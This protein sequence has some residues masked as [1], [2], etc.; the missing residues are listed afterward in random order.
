MQ[1]LNP[2]LKSMKEWNDTKNYLVTV[3]VLAEVI[4]ER[5]S[6]LPGKFLFH[7]FPKRRNHIVE[8]AKNENVTVLYTMKVYIHTHRLTHFH[9][10][11]A[12]TCTYI[13][14]HL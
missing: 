5:I 13:H 14:I 2:L 1:D 4:K 12:H 11:I 9:T 3:N 7:F 10:H 8:R 6:S